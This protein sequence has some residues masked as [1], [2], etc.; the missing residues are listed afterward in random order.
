MNIQNGLKC[1]LPFH[2]IKI[3]KD[4]SIYACDSNLT[5]PIGNILNNSL[6]EIWNGI[7][8]KKLRNEILC[9]TYNKCNTDRCLILNNWELAKQIPRFL[10]SSVK[11]LDEPQ[12]IRFHIDNSCNLVCPG[13]REK[14]VFVQENDDNHHMMFNVIKKTLDELFSEPHDKKYIIT[15]DNGGEFFASLAWKRILENEQIFINP[16]LWPNT[17]FELFTA[18]VLMTPEWQ[19]NYKKLLLQTKHISISVRAGNEDSYKIVRGDYWNQLWE[20]ISYLM[21]NFDLECIWSI[22][23]DED[24]YESIPDLIDIAYTFNNLPR[25]RFD[26]IKY[27]GIIPESKNVVNENHYKHADYLRIMELDK[28]KN[29]PK[30]LDHR[31]DEFIINHEPY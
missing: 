2:H 8:L 19:N 17:R 20:N 7:E 22:V 9:G 14:M 12:H 16:D 27:W 31:S 25:L 30:I 26:R 10:D 28:V 5:S 13:C 18:G 11:I 29:Y 4:G 3:Y 15:F 21:N 24:T 6:Y 23:V 1:Q